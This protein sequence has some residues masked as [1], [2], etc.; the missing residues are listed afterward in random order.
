MKF[1]DWFWKWYETYRMKNIRQVTQ[2]KYEAWYHRIVEDEFGSMPLK[3]ITRKDVQEF[4][5]RYGQSRSKHTA[6]TFSA[7]LK[8]CFRDAQ[9]DG[10][11]KNSPHQHIEVEYREKH[12]TVDQLKSKREEKKWLNLNE[13]ERMKK[14]MIAWLDNFLED[15][16]VTF[17]SMNNRATRAMQF[18]MMIIFIALKTGCRF[19]EIVGIT[20][21][22]IKSESMEINIDK[23][24]NYKKAK[25]E[26]QPTKN[27][28]SIRNVLVD[29]ETIKII[30]K[31]IFWKDANTEYDKNLP[32]FLEPGKRIFNS[33]IN[34]T[35]SYVFRSLGIETI[36]FHKLRHT[37]ASILIAKK[38]P[39]QVIAKRLGHT[40][41]NMIQRVYGHLIKEVEDEGNRMIREII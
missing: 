32:L 41:T 34:N 20:E 21:R 17:C 31:F 12:Y 40:D 3:K 1:S 11:I 16:P 27:I 13:Y 30:E 22:D 23:T 8:A 7:I 29:Q 18:D 24:W 5:N 25:G 6:V 39:L 15:G 35:L 37:Q 38:V 4:V 33:S 14:F 28:S 36:S 10:L 26:F 19:S 2:Q 9:I